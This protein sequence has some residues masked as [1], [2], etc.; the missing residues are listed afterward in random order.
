MSHRYPH[1]SIARGV[2]LWFLLTLGSAIAA[3]WMA[4]P[5]LP[6]WICSVGG[7]MGA[8]PASDDGQAA[9]AA[10]GFSCPLCV[11][12]LAPPPAPVALPLA[13]APAVAPHG[14]AQSGQPD[15]RTGLPGARGP[16]GLDAL[17]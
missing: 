12:M 7:G 6:Q 2:L 17:A 5:S 1:R 3:P 16:P 10:Q 14:L 4:G 15:T 8:M 11:Q 9:P 13:L